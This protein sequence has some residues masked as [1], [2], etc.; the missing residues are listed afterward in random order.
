MNDGIA[1]ARAAAPVVTERVG[2]FMISP[3][4]WGPAYGALSADEAG[5]LLDLLEKLSRA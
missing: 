2:G 1:T 5:E 3:M 4:N